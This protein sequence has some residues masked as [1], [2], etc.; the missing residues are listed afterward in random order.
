MPETRRTSK[1]QFTGFAKPLHFEAGHID[2]NKAMDPR[3][4][5]DMGFQDYVDFLC[6]LGYTNEQMIIVVKRNECRVVTNV[7][8][9]T[10]VYKHI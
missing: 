10:S 5:Y 9:D 8:N 6:A 2:P 3:L 1:S 7:G 4:N